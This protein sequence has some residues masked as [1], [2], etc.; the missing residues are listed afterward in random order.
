MRVLDRL[1][2]FINLL[3]IRYE[4]VPCSSCSGQLVFT[5]LTQCGTE[6]STGRNAFLKQ[7]SS[8]SY[9]K[10]LAKK[11]ALQKYLNLGGK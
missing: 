3:F 1:T 10:K 6:Y 8:K 5:S 11:H 7:I 9:G 2:V 4:T